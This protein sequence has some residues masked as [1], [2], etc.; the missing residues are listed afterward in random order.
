M[1]YKIRKKVVVLK[2]LA[3]PSKLVETNQKT[4]VYLFF[5]KKPE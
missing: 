5:N 4:K 1:Q 3:T 2:L